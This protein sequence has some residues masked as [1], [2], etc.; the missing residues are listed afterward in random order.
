MTESSEHLKPLHEYPTLDQAQAAAN[1]QAIAEMSY[2]LPGSFY[3]Q[4]GQRF[5]RSSCPWI[6]S[7]NSRSSPRA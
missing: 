6:N 2:A 3:V 4:G 1:S 7:L 5:V